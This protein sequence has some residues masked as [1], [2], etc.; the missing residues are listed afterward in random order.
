VEFQ[1][2]A[3]IALLAWEVGVGDVKIRR[4]SRGEA[5]SFKDRSESEP[6]RS[7]WTNFE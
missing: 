7:D 3:C 6:I 2:W 5:E 4:A 1:I